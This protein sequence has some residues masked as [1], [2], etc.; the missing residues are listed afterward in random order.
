[1]VWLLSTGLVLAVAPSF[2]QRESIGRVRSVLS[3]AVAARQAVRFAISPA[4]RDMPSPPRVAPGPG[5]DSD[6]E[7]RDIESVRSE[8]VGP[9]LPSADGALQ[10]VS[11]WLATMPQPFLT[12]EGLSDADNKATFGHRVIPPDT[13]GDVGPHFYVQMVNVTFRIFDKR[14]SPLTPPRQLSDLFAPLGPPCNIVNQGDGVTLYDPLADRWLI[15]QLCLLT[16]PFRH[17]LI[18]IS[19]TSDPRGAYYLYDF[20]MPN[21]KFN[22][23]P[24]FGVWPDAYYMT[25][26]EFDSFGQVFL[27]T[28]VFAFDRTRMLV[29]DPTAS[30]IYKDLAPLDRT[31]GGMLPADMDG[32]RPP[33]PGT[34]DYFASFTADEFK[35]PGD[36]LRLFE[37]HADF[38]NPANSTFT[39]RPESPIV[40]A[41]FNP[42]APPGRNCIPQPPPADDATASLDALSDRLMHRL[43][44]RDFGDHESLVV[45]HTVNVS[46]GLTPATYHAGVRYYELRRPLPGGAFAVGEQATFAPDSENRWM[47]SAAQDA[48]GNLVVGYSVSGFDTL[49]S[50][51]YAGRLA[52]DPP[53]GLFQGEATLYPGTFVQQSISHRWGDYSAL[54]VDPSDDCTFWYTNEYYQADD[55]NTTAEW[56]TR[57]GLFSFPTCV[58]P[59]QGTVQGVVTLSGS[60]A[61]IPGVTVRSSDGFSRTTDANGT[62]AMS[63]AAGSYD[64]TASGPRVYAKDATGVVLTNGVVTIQNFVLDPHLFPILLAA[65]ASGIADESCAPASGTL[66]PGESLSMSFAIRNTGTAPTTNLVASLEASG[67]ILSPGPPQI[68]GA[69]QPGGLVLKTFSFTVDPSLAC[70]SRLTAT[71]DL[72]DGAID[73]GSVRYDLPVGGLGPSITSAYDTGDIAVPIPDLGTV[74]VP[75]DVSDDGTIQSLDVEVRLDHPLDS[76]LELSIVHPDGT[77]VDLADNPG[78]SGLDHIANF[79]TGPDSCAGTPAVFVDSPEAPPILFANPYAGPIN[80]IDPLATISGK[81]QTGRWNLRVADDAAGHVGT[82]GCVRLRITRTQP[83]CCPFT[84]GQP[85]LVPAPPFTTRAE[86]CHPGNEAP[87]ADETVSLEIPL[88]NI[89]NGAT[90]NLVATLLPDDGVGSPGSPQ[91]YGVVAPVG[92]PVSRVFQFVPRGTCG[93]DIAATI[94]LDDVGGA[95]PLGTVTVPIRL[96]GDAGTQASLSSPGTIVLSYSRVGGAGLPYPATIQAMDPDLL[97]PIPG[98]VESVSVDVLGLSD[99]NFNDTSSVHLLLVPPQGP[100]IMLM[101]GCG[102][103]FTIGYADLTFDDSA[104]TPMPLWGP[105]AS[106]VYQPRQCMPAENMAAPA[107]PG[108]YPYPSRLADLRGIDPNGIW[109]LYASGNL[110]FVKGDPFEEGFIRGGWRLNIR[111]YDPVCCSER[112]GLTCPDETSVSSEPGR[113]GASISFAAPAASGSCGV[114]TCS[115]TSGSVFGLG[116]SEA[117]CGGLSSANAPTGECRFGVT[118][119]APTTTRVD[120]VSVQ[121]SDVAMLRGAVSSEG[122][123]DYGGTLRFTTDAAPA[124]AVAVSGS[125]D[126]ALA[127]QVLLP[128]GDHALAAAFDSAT[129]GVLGSSGAAA[130][131]VLRE[132]ATV[133]A[134]PAAPIAARVD[135]PGGTATVPLEASIAE[136]SDG[137]PGD[138]TKAVPVTFSLTPALGAQPRSCT[139]A[140]GTVSSGTLSLGCS[141]AGLPVDLYDL[142]IGVG[143]DYYQ[144]RAGGVVVVYDPTAGGASGGGALAH[145]G[146]AADFQLDARYDRKGTLHGSLLFVDHRPAGDVTFVG[147]ADGALAVVGSQAV[148]I[149]SGSLGGAP[150][151]AF[152]LRM[153]DDGGPGGLDALGLQVTDPAGAPVAGLSFAPVTLRNGN[154]NVGASQ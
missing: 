145:D 134:I 81:T 107:P 98:K 133:T 43:A 76:D 12:F 60:G 73:L 106:G 5:D 118:V 104:P 115:P 4:V 121:Y 54:S 52:G 1:M 93:A 35:D 85:T 101:A 87:D 103:Q 143:G 63:L 100:P 127:D 75:I 16:T 125:G 7:V 90:R 49:P 71:L 69:L 51:R 9:V 86:S 131:T 55:P 150:G 135:G 112:C 30:Y 3:G 89:G 11:P 97:G 70:G 154:L 56:Q 102:N 40:V 46:G 80:P 99:T 129:T 110:A 142:D 17:E 111:T 119:T 57:V 68:Y 72:S 53:N 122:C 50:I 130:L 83:L 128:A 32:L 48:Q 22:D 95:G 21:D 74:D 94:A 153:S 33:P 13:N 20:M 109:S 91:S 18:A 15:S 147:T 152:R 41:P 62:Y 123:P 105:I 82:V 146:V 79:G 36:A 64:L 92:P 47:G 58:P 65:G 137:S 19:Q 26:N 8:V 77:V 148:L 151:F 23:Y 44:Y 24:K 38:A 108:P 45:T 139:A 126:V 84:S 140:G 88:R 96:G 14:G 67:G 6:L 25:D 141:V 66:D 144:G 34:P 124:G 116:A 78:L 117:V 136:V 29:G 113:C 149:G 28:G 2:A 61:P 10:S 31:I 59:A 114:V 39:E 27:G 42:L 37:F 120:P 138:I 132:D